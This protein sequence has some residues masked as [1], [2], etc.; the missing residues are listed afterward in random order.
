MKKWFALLGLTLGLV[1]DAAMAQLP[2]FTGLVER[3]SPAVV[4]ITTVEDVHQLRR[5]RNLPSPND[6]FDFFRRML[7]PDAD[8]QRDP[9]QMLPRHGQGSGFIISSDGYILT[10][11]HVVDEADEVMVKLHDK[12]EFR[13]KV[14]GSDPST[15]VA[16]IKIN[17]TNLPT[18]ASTHSASRIPSPPASSP[19]RDAACRTRT[20]Y[21]SSRPTSRSIRAIPAAPCST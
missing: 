20:T 15:D 9:H 12:R 7:P 13:A 14:V 19:P 16:L 6:M 10:N 11:T 4:N 17:A 2:D 5:D 3:E 21:R 8:V 18:V 1:S